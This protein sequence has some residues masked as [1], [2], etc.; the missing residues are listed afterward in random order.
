MTTKIMSIAA[1]AAIMMTG[2]NAFNSDTTGKILANEGVDGNYSWDA[3]SS[4]ALNDLNI[5]SAFNHGDALIYP[6]FTQADGWSSEVYVRNDSNK[7]IVAKVALYTANDSQEVK[8]FNIY[9]SPNDAFR[10]NIVNDA[11]IL[12]EDSVVTSAP[13]PQDNNTAGE[14]SADTVKFGDELN[15]SLDFTTQSGYVVVYAMAETNVTEHHNHVNLF[16]EYRALLDGAR[17]GWR[18]GFG[19]GSIANFENGTYKNG[20]T[21][22]ALL[23]D[24]SLVTTSYAWSDPSPVLTGTIRVLKDSDDLNG[25]RDMIINAIPMNNYSDD[26]MIV[27]TEGETAS[28]ADRRLDQNGTT[29][30]YAAQG[31]TVGVGIGAD[32]TAFASNGFYYRFDNGANGSIANNLIFTQP[33]KRILTQLGNL[34]GYWTVVPGATPGSFVTGEEYEFATQCAFWDE[35]E[36]TFVPDSPDGENGLITSPY[37]G[38]EPGEVESQYNQEVTILTEQELE[39]GEAFGGIYDN[40]HGYSSCAISTMPPAIVSQMIGSDVGGNALT[41][42]VYSVNRD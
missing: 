35:K 29:A 31:L 3:N 7:S 13:L 32:A 38:E 2:A 15:A 41:N 22:P 14:H 23:G 36:N 24:G 39:K 25:A 30:D 18:K 8:D 16:G 5:S 17:D 34:D 1:A 4:T 26:N 10:F 27:W 20:I 37:N 6:Y 11:I 33:F 28:L 21:S 12:N 19:P 9:L 42:W 40:V